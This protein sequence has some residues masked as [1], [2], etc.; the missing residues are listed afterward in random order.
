[1]HNFA[2]LVLRPP[3]RH[4]GGQAPDEDRLKTLGDAMGSDTG[5][6]S[7]YGFQLYDTSGTTE[8]W[9]YGAA[10]TFGYTIEM[11]P[12]AGDG[13]N[14]HVSYDRAV[15][16]QWTGSGNRAGRGLRKALTRIAQEAAVRPD[17]ST[18]IGRAPAGRILRLKKTFKTSTSPVCEIAGPSDVSV[19]PPE[20]L[21]NDDCI[22]PGDVQTVDDKLEYK[23]TVPAN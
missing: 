15:V 22:S 20:P 12:E 10:G 18:L 13:G 14:F 3:G 19:T 4:D 11:G 8:D 23:T 16:E 7:Q 1:M 2:S 9:N 6:T 5:Y 17:F 21:P